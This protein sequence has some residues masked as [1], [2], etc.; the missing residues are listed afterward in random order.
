MHELAVTE[1]IV[2]IVKQALDGAGEGI[3]VSRVVLKIG[4]FST[5]VPRFVEHYYDIITEGTPLHGAKIDAEQVPAVA[6]CR[7]CG[8]SFEL[9][10]MDFT[11]PECGGGDTELKTGRELFVEYIEVK[12]P[13]EE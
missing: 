1:E 5:V 4:K 2:K 6:E 12:E 10:E 8:A 3:R 7:S 13:G 9:G 11:C